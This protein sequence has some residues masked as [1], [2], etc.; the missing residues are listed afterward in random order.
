[1]RHEESHSGMVVKNSD[2]A[3]DVLSKELSLSHG[4]EGLDIDIQIHVTSNTGVTTPLIEE[5]EGHA[6][7]YNDP[8]PLPSPTVEKSLPSSSSKS[9]LKETL[10]IGRPEMRAV[11][12]T[13]ILKL[14]GFETLAVLACGPGNMMDD[15][16]AAIVDAYGTGEGKVCPST[17]EYFE[18]S[19]S[20]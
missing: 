16:R 18:E 9:S 4:P 3:T 1:M 20:W 8:S 15:M 7:A 10:L 17:L 14:V 19:F 12:Q 6:L 5:A 11:L 2:Y 13:S